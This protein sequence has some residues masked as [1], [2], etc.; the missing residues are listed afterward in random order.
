MITID[1]VMVKVETESGLRELV[2]AIISALNIRA[3]KR[4]SDSLFDRGAALAREMNAGVLHIA[5]EGFTT[6]EEAMHLIQEKEAVE[7]GEREVTDESQW[8][9][10][11][12]TG[13]GDE[14]QYVPISLET[15]AGTDD[16]EWLRDAH[17][18]ANKAEAE[19][20]QAAETIDIPIVGEDAPTL[21]NITE[22]RAQADARIQAESVSEDLTP[23]LS[24]IS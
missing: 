2:H 19:R 8:L 10:T 16:V 7:A 13:I 6:I 11:R 15:V 22:M 20:T 3:G 12:R 18:A 1:D 5:F 21:S 17:D 24:V 23:Q 14:S 9:V 4:D